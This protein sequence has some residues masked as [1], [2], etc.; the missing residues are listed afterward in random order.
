M[1]AV[2]AVSGEPVIE[3]A[4]TKL[5]R[6][7][8]LSRKESIQDYIIT[9]SQKW[10]DGI[11]T[12]KGQV[13]QFVAMPIGGVYSV[14]KQVTGE[15]VAGGLQI[16][17]IPAKEQSPQKVSPQNHSSQSSHEELNHAVRLRKDLNLNRAFTP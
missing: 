11:A 17:I 14:E 12:A 3:T 9:P 16:E 13:R 8:L 10:L 1:G 7:N 6:Q 15:E 2:N 5:R 4:A